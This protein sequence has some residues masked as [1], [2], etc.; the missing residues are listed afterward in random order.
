MV[1]TN[2]IKHILGDKMTNILMDIITKCVLRT[3]L[4]YEGEF[5]AP[6]I[7]ISKEDKNP[8]FLS[9]P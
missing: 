2:I 8:T 5:H 1:L 4:C 9:I 3:C 6:Q 7:F